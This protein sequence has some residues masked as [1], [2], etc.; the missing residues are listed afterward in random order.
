MALYSIEGNL[1]PKGYQQV[2][3]LSAVKALTIPEDAEIAVIQA[4]SQ[5]VRWRDDGIGPT[6]SVGMQLAAGR[7]ML[8]TSKLSA[9]RFIEEAASAKLNVSYYAR[10]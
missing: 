1:I 2:T 5:N 10:G 6:A 3:S 8:F 4:E 7:D 9:V